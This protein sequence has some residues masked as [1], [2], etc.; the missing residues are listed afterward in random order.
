MLMGMTIEHRWDKD[1]FAAVLAA[2]ART[3]VD[4]LAALTRIERRQILMGLNLERL[5]AAATAAQETIQAIAED[6]PQIK[7]LVEDLRAKLTDPA[8]QAKI[9]AITE[10][11]TGIT[12][13]AASADAEFDALTAPITDE[14]PAEPGV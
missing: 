14:T 10:K 9:D 13:S 1:Q 5:E 3:S 7:A 11:L 6:V 2:L 4:V 12:A 8:D